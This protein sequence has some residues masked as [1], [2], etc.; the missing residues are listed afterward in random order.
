MLFA[1]FASLHGDGLN[2]I[3]NQKAG[4]LIEAH[5]R[6]LGIIRQSIKPEEFFHASQETTIQLPDAPGAFEMRLQFVFFRILRTEVCDRC[7]QYP[8]STALS[9]SSRKFHSA[10]PSGGSLQAKAVT[11]ARWWPS[12][13]IGLPE[14]GWSAR[15]CNPLA[16]YLFTQFDRLVWLTCSVLDTAV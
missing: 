15:T 14:R 3:A 5:H 11:L 12:I 7:S 1:H 9:A 2:P 6:V 4:P 10:Y 13:S 8:S 16:R